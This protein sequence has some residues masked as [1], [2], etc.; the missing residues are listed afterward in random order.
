MLILI[1]HFG[2]LNALNAFTENDE[3][4]VFL[5]FRNMDSKFNILICFF[6][7]SKEF[8]NRS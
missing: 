3:I 8:L 5:L 4:L 2:V 1:E 6:K 7:Y